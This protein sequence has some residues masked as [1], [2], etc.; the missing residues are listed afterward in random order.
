MIVA[1]P[2]FPVSLVRPPTVCARRCRQKFLRYFPRGFRDKK[3]IDWERGYKWNAHLQWEEQ[4]ARGTFRKLL[5]DGAYREVAIRALRIESRTNLLF[6][7]EKMAMR[8][9]T[10]EA[11]GAKLFAEGLFA[12]LHGP[13]ALASRFEA[14]V[15]SV[16]AL[17]RVQTRVLTWPAVTIFPFLAQ[18]GQHF[19]LKPKVTK[20]A[21]QAYGFPLAYRSLPSWEIYR[22]CFDFAERV[23]SDLADL[24]PADYID[25]QSF[26]WV[27]GSDEYP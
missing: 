14:W 3:Y 20:V 10:R 26:I 22:S 11:A 16:G 2:R 18:P 17:P 27:Q 4:L 19:F 25:L 1:K 13:G 24:A 23:R 6:S 12:M 7:F 21:A 9:A 15:D 5:D 8:D